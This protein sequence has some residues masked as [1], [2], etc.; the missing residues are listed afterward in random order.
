[1]IAM[2]ALSFHPRPRATLLLAVALPCL[3]GLGFWQLDRGREREAAERRLEAR[4]EAP[5]VALPASVVDAESWRERHVAVAGR[6]QPARQFLLDNRVRHGQA[7]YEV[8]T[9]LRLS[10]SDVAVLVNRGWVAAPADRQQLPAVATPEGSVV[11]DGVAVVPPPWTFT[12]GR[13]DAGWQPV[14]QHLDLERF[15]ALTGMR[16]QPVVVRLSPQSPAGGFARDW[17]RADAGAARN[18]GYAVQWFGFAVAAVVVWAASAVER[19]QP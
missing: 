2:A 9:P 5:A 16:L 14:W 17:P 15:R 11:A 10:G 18:F 12:L 1:M 13:P 4:M 8:V 3:I 19:R 7:G 6:Y